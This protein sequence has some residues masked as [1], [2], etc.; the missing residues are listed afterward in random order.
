M[1]DLLIPATDFSASTVVDAS[2]LNLI[3]TEVS[4][5]TA[6]LGAHRT[7]NIQG[8]DGTFACGTSTAVE[9]VINKAYFDANAGT[10][11][12]SAIAALSARVAV[13]ETYSLKETIILSDWPYLS[14]RNICID[15][16]SGNDMYISLGGHSAIHAGPAGGTTIGET[17][18]HYQKIS[19]YWY[20]NVA[21]DIAAGASIYSNKGHPKLAGND[22]VYSMP[23]SFYF[24]SYSKVLNFIGERGVTAGNP[25]EVC[26]IP[27]SVPTVSSYQLAR[28]CAISP[29]GTYA[30]MGYTNNSSSGPTLYVDVFKT[31]VAS[32][33]LF[34][35]VVIDATTTES[36]TK[37]WDSLVLCMNDDY[38]VTGTPKHNI[39]KGYAQ[40]LKR[41][42][43]TWALSQTLLDSSGSAL[44]WFGNGANFEDATTLHISNKTGETITYTESGGTWTQSN[45]ITLSPRLLADNRRNRA[46]SWGSTHVWCNTPPSDTTVGTVVLYGSGSSYSFDS[47]V[48]PDADATTRWAPWT[49]T[50]TPGDE[51]PMAFEGGTLAVSWVMMDSRTSSTNMYIENGSSTYITIY[52]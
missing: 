40:V 27:A 20:A 1:T 30:A 33:W 49:P 18:R 22:L 14:G 38:I 23:T 16:V 21:G 5:A 17:L 51:Q 11:T 8:V 36:S 25:S 32:G 26:R 37:N 43:A 6:K 44:D 34:Q 52:D 24:T 2:E 50:G 45:K 19:G 4:A 47:P 28:G 3:Q 41:T 46:G 12:D 10:A 31:D 9:H 39:N 35:N 15:P 7:D 29:S 42:G 13:F 48:A